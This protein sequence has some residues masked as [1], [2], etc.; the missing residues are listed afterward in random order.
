MTNVLFLRS[1]VVKAMCIEALN[2]S[3]E[4]KPHLYIIKIEIIL[5]LLIIFFEKMNKQFG[6]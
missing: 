5:L 4:N 3:L 1:N 6:N 2:E